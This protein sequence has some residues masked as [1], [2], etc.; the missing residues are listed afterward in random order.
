MPI[1]IPKQI[2][3]QQILNDDVNM[4]EKAKQI[5]GRSGHFFPRKDARMNI[6]K[7]TISI[8]LCIFPNVFP[9]LVPTEE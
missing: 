1:Y 4:P 3:K 5:T 9:A 2:S 8:E 6:K 7:N